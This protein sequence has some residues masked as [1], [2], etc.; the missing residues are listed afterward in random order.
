MT[1][2]QRVAIHCIAA[3]IML[4]IA[5]GAGTTSAQEKVGDPGALCP[6]RF[7]RLP[8]RRRDMVTKTWRHSPL[9]SMICNR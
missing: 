3:L 5:F 1:Q 4:P 6:S 8:N 2:N 7:P 9:T